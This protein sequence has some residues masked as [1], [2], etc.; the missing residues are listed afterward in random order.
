MNIKLTEETMNKYSV[1]LQ[2]HS[3]LLPSEAVALQGIDNQTMYSNKMNVNQ[4]N[5]QRIEIMFQRGT[6][7]CKIC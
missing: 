3:S 7:C 1:N 6:P 2:I 5:I 4:I